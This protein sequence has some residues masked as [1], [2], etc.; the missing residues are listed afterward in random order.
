MAKRSG[1]AEDPR[2]AFLLKALAA[3]L[4]TAVGA[5]AARAQFFGRRPQPLPAGRSSS[6]DI[7]HRIAAGRKAVALKPTC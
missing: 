2:R 5:G 4:L 7:N 1:E 6:D 3:G